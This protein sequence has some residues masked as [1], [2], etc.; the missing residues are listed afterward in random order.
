MEPPFDI[1][2]GL[3]ISDI[4][5]NDDAVGASVICACNS[6]ESLLARGI[7]YLQFN[8]FTIYL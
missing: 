3:P 5:H 4:V 8:S 1:G 7:P 2:K 6:S